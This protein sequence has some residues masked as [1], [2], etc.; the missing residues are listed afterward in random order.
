MSE[1]AASVRPCF[2]FEIAAEPTDALRQQFVRAMVTRL[3]GLNADFREALHEYAE[4]L[5][6]EV[7]LYRVGEGPFAANAGRIKQ[8]RLLTAAV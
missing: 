7:R 5:Q 4:T 6:P 2:L 8:V 1:Q 3:E